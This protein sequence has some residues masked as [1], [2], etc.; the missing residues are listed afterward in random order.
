[1][2]HDVL[3]RSSDSVRSRF[4]A[5]VDVRAS[6]DC[7]LW[8]GTRSKKQYGKFKIGSSCYIAGRLSLGAEL[9][10]DLEPHEFACHH[11]DNPPCVNPNH[12]FAG[13]QLENMADAVKKGRTHRWS[14]HRAGIDN[15]KARLTEGNVL[16]IRRLRGLETAKDIGLRFGVSIGTI[17][18]IYYQRTWRKLS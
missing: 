6:N 12:L 7:W 15:P 2:A 9:G 17:H 8:T 3:S 18:D 1:M 4:W 13:S 10:R 11:C 16:E 5:K 14:G